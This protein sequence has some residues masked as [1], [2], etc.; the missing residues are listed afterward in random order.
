VSELRRWRIL[1]VVPTYNEARTLPVTLAR[2]RSS[3]P[4]ADV[5]VVDDASPDGTGR[6]AEQIAGGDHNVHVL[7]RDAKNGLGAAYVAG[8][9]WG[10]EQ[11]Y[12]IVVEMDADG[13]H[14]PEQLGTLLAALE[15]G[16]GLVIGSRWVPG[17]E[18]VNWPRRRELLSRAAN[19]YVRL[20]T[21]LPVRDATAGF[22]AYRSDVLR[23]V[24]LN[25]VHSHG[26][27]F[28]V[29]MALRVREAGWRLVEV[30]ITFVER[31]VGESKMSRGIILEALARTTWW[32][33]RH[34]VGQ[35]GRLLLG[36]RSR[37]GGS[38]AA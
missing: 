11:M 5:L 25:A 30:P 10:L 3:E 35:A 27:C 12:D 19:R 16:P 33:L 20:G 38:R 13:S 32:G 34:R 7:H 1:V 29:D 14:Q 15:D 22:R 18:V 6:I 24:D 26:Y 4:G 8:F 28:Q 17:G 21:G 37:A 23:A 9:Q 31:T 36:R 2:L